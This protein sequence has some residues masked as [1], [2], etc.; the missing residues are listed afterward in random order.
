MDQIS[1]PLLLLVAVLIAGGIYIRR[2]YGN[3]SERLTQWVEATTGITAAT[4]VRGLALLTL[5]AWAV[6]FLIQGGAEEEGLDAIFEKFLPDR[7]E[8]E[9]GEP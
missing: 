9:A 1:L 8:P 5:L 2:R 4:I 7:Q 3:L 6:I